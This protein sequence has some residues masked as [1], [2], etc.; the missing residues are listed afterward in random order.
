MS[1]FCLLCCLTLFTLLP[2]EAARAARIYRLVD[3]P[4]LQNGHALTGTITTTDDAP[5]DSVLQAN[6]ILD[7]RWSIT[8]AS[9]LSATHA[10][11]SSPDLPT[12]R[13]E[14]IT[15]T[16]ASIEI[17]FDSSAVLFLRQIDSGFGPLI[18]SVVWFTE[19]NN[20]TGEYATQNAAS[21]FA[22]DILIRYWLNPLA[23]S[24]NSSRWIVA[25]IVPEPL[26]GWLMIEAFIC[27]SFRR[28]RRRNNLLLKT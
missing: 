15:I 10:L 23:Q 19:L 13:A 8:G 7:W 22:G 4:A 21:Y 14:G 18:R 9:K 5:I 11:P 26:S 12:T 20:M 17:P 28:V 16:S 6:E 24:P 2:A 27:L 25:T 3:Y 1:R